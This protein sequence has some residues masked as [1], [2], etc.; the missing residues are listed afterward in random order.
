[1]QSKFQFATNLLALAL[2]GSLFTACSFHKKKYENPVTK[3][4]LQPDKV[5]FDRAIGGHRA[6]EVSK[7]RG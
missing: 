7:W 2:A 6:R 4:T 3:D 1:M 5:L